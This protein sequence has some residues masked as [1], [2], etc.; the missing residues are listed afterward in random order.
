L[1][2]ENKGELSREDPLSE[3]EETRARCRELE[4]RLSESEQTLEAIRSGEVDAI[5]ISTRS[6]EKIFTLKGAEEPYRILFEQMNEVAVTI[7]EDGGILYTNQS[8]ATAMETSLEKVFGANIE[9]FI[10]PGQLFIFRELL[11]ESKLAPVR[12]EFQFRTK[13]GKALPMQISVSYLPTVDVPT[14]CIVAADMSERIQAEARLNKAYGEL[15]VKV[16]ERTSELLRTTDELEE[17]KARLETILK[18][19]PVAVVIVE[20]P[21]GKVVFFN[22]EVH[23]LYGMREA[24]LGNKGEFPSYSTFHLDGTRYAP[25]EYP[26][27]RSLK[28]GEPVLNEIIEFERSDG[29]R[30]FANSNAVAVKDVDGH[31]TAVIGLR[32]EITEQ[33]E[34]ERARQA[35][36]NRLHS[37]LDSLPAG[38][39]V[40]DSN[41][42]PV[43]M[44][45]MIK[46]MVKN[47]LWDSDEEIDY[48]K[49]VGFLPGMEAPLLV[50]EWPVIRAIRRGEGMNGA[51]M[52]LERVDG[53]RVSILCFAVPIMEEGRNLGGI[54][55]FVDITDQKNAEKALARS[56]EEL[57]NFAYVASHDLQEPLRMVISYLSL[58]ERRYRDQLDEQ[59][60]EFI[61]FAVTGGKRMKVLIDDLLEYSRVDTQVRPSTHVDMDEIVSMTLRNLEPSINESG[62]EI[63]VSQMPMVNGDA[64]QLTQVLQNLVSNAIKFHGDRKP[65][66]HI[67]CSQDPE[68]WICHV[69]DNGIGLNMEY[70]SRI[71]QM[72]QRLNS[73]DKYEGTG[74]GLAIVKKIVERHGGK[75]WVE[76]EEGKGAT[77]FF[78][79]PKE[80]GRSAGHR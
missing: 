45:K 57:K 33:I 8:F 63:F 77:F 2:R 29:T 5:L 61:D 24:Q 20:P 62:A 27:Y 12:S 44:N 72:F 32:F 46:E 40:I 11:Q 6:G 42:H 58:L 51:E 35:E 78:T 60:N 59:A 3:L 49:V 64:Q 9:D 47:E 79:L 30:G 75:V 28:T 67:G 76:S 21:E 80:R 53:S 70:S 74:V 15:E 19:M 68:K 1:S 25:N 14:Y 65:V 50:N 43:I 4:R 41:G 7:S 54:A 16:Q 39:V 22:E 38:V 17:T 37:I 34:A 52:E 18:V 31:I 26:M 13:D 73:N 48:D 66:I 56:N 55:A 69:K 36:R 71:F 10:G 23:R